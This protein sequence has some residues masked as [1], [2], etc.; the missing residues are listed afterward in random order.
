[1]EIS[2]AKLTLIVIASIIVG[3]AIAIVGGFVFVYSMFDTGR[4]V[5]FGDD[6]KRKVVASAPYDAAARGFLD[7][8]NM[9]WG[10]TPSHN[11]PQLVIGDA[12]I[13]G[14]TSVDGQ[15]LAGL[16]L[17]L[18]LN[19]KVISNWAV[20]DAAGRYEISVPPGKY[21]VSGFEFDRV[22][23]NK[24][25]AGKIIRPGCL[26]PVR[27]GEDRPPFE[28]LAAKTGTGINFEFIDPVELLAPEGEVKI[29]S[30]LMAQWKPYPGAARYRIGL[31]ETPPRMTGGTSNSVF[32]WKARPEVTGESLDLI[33]AGLVPKSGQDY[34]I[35]IE[36]LDAK[37]TVISESPSMLGRGYF[38]L[39]K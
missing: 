30:E 29:G 11:V 6:T 16:R 2:P 21:V 8:T 5:S 31:Y 26:L 18:N 3:I 24:L 22:A 33:K 1:M 7:T 13:V 34:S 39:M 27:C 36:A 4:S 19:S 32:D 28:V 37:G 15:P 20:T 14:T 25:L 35:K 38:R 10:D 23:A 12:R 17:R 9:T